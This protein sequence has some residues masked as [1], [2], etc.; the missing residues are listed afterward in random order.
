M[1]FLLKSDFHVHC[2]LRPGGT[3]MS[4]LS[5]REGHLCPSVQTGGDINGF[6]VITSKM[7]IFKFWKKIKFLFP[8]FENNSYKQNAFHVPAS[9]NGWT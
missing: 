7:M 2:H 9:L 8:K 3:F 4:D 6:L 5:D 1:Q